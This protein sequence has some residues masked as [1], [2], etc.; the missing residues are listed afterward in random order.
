MEKLVTL[1]SIKM[2]S[3][4]NLQNTAPQLAEAKII[5]KNFK[6]HIQ[7]NVDQKELPQIKKYFSSFTK[8]FTKL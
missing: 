6:K 8:I 1:Y 7:N 4:W 5:D 2:E 3:R